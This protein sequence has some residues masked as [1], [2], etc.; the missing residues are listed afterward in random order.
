MRSSQRNVP[1]DVKLE[2]SR[3]ESHLW[4]A[5]EEGSPENEAA[6]EKQSHIFGLYYFLIRGRQSFFQGVGSKHG[7]SFVLALVK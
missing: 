4:Q 1:D 6:S 5:S 7:I 2:F 3:L